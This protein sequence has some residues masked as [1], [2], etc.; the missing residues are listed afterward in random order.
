M[1]AAVAVG[2]GL[3]FAPPAGSPLGPVVA[4]A[5]PGSFTDAA[6]LADAVADGRNLER[7]RKWAEAIRHYD[8]ALERFA[9]DHEAPGAEPLPEPIRA[10]QY[11][12]RRSKIHHGIHRRYADPS[13]TEQLLSRSPESALDLYETVLG[14]IRR[15]YVEPIGATSLVAHGT[16]SLYLALSDRKFLGRNLPAHGADDGSAEAAV[17]RFRAV[18]RTEFWNAPIRA[19]DERRTVARAARLGRELCGLSETATIFEYLAG[20]TNALDDYS[21]FLSPEGLASLYGNIEGNFVGIGIEIEAEPG[22]GQFLRKILP[23][24]PAEEG[25]AKAGE[26]VSAIGGTDC[27]DL[28]TDEA[29]KLL[30]GP[31]FS[32]VELEITDAR[33][34]ARTGRFVRR[35]VEVA[36]VERAE[37]VEPGIGY[38]RMGGFQETTAREMAD[39]VNQLRRQGM[40]KLIWDLRG[41][42]G[43]LL[44]AAVD[45][46]DLFVEEG[47]LV[48]TRGPAGGQT[49][50][51][52]ARR[53]GTLAARD[54]ELVLLVDGD[55][56]SAS[57]IVAGCLRDHRRGTIV[58]RT[59]YGKWSVQSIVDLG[60]A[61]RA[62]WAAAAAGSRGSGLK[63]T[64]ARFYSPDGRNYAGI[65]LNPDVPAPEYADDAQEPEPTEAPEDLFAAADPAAGI[66]GDRTA[67]YRPGRVARAADGPR[68]PQTSLPLNE[69]PDVQA[70][71]K[72]LRRR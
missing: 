28:S 3:L 67:G 57:E 1:V 14:Q 45:V 31:E 72:L 19:E 4:N 40:T 39:A 47:T 24:S 71:L 44:D 56:A 15:N 29:A 2:G 13:Y 61:P 6:E 55:S 22:R 42:P 46:L 62:G 8:A 69:Q 58:G 60:D 36:S 37:M 53:A 35:T 34:V 68:V 26:Y 7:A 10:L 5:A 63:L 59:T 23:G 27:R 64:T 16:E 51:Y 41:N 52:R 66:A 50:T 25:G 33:G 30:R 9:P 17:E 12:L 65:G 49:Q 70:A 48:S 11:G 21:A 38:I 43:G 54:L 18:L 32:A 20:A